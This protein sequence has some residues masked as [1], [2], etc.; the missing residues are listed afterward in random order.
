MPSI[1][2][3][4]APLMIQWTDGHKQ[5]IAAAF[6]HAKGLLYLDPFWHQS[7]P[8]KAAHLIKGELRGEGPWRIDNAVIR[9]LGCQGTDPELQTAFSEWQ[10]YLHTRSEE[11]PPREQIKGI[12]RKLGA[13]V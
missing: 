10:H 6:P 7:T 1:D 8:A 3:I 13:L 5:L 12:A 4:T 9:V 11:Y 2:E